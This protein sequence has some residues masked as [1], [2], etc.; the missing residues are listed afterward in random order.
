MWKG[1]APPSKPTHLPL[2]QNRTVP[3]PHHGD[4]TDSATK[5]MA[6]VNHN[7][8]LPLSPFSLGTSSE[9]HLTERGCLGKS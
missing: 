5:S 4:Q 1:P 6:T 9:S 8:S 3:A 7:T 2:P